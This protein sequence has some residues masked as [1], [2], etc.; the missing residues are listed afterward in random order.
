MTHADPP[1]G[2]PSASVPSESDP[3]YVLYRPLPAR[4]R[5]FLRV[6]VPTMLWS[7]VIVAFVWARAQQ[8]P[9]PAVWDDAVARS[10]AGAVRM[11]PY[12]ML[13]LPAKDGKPAEVLLIVEVGKHGAQQRL[14]PLDGRMA[15]LSG[16]LLER[17]GRRML[18]LE[19][20]ALPQPAGEPVPKVAEQVLGRAILRGEVVDAKCFLGAMKPGAGKPHKACATL[21]VRGGLPAVFI[22][23]DPGSGPSFYVLSGSDGDPP[24]AWFEGMIADPV[25]VEGEHRVVGDLDLLIVAPGSIRRL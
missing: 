20:G 24:G 14:R 10:F 25:E 7:L 9:G 22:P 19:P 23:H 12:P 1:K 16:W 18:E 17:D 15:T 4:N 3:I 11:E 8:P 5:R 6:Y 21:C 2:Q 13:V